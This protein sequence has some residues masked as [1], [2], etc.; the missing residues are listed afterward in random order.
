MVIF[1]V[2]AS[3]LIESMKAESWWA[4][5]RNLGPEGQIK[6]IRSTVSLQS[7][8]VFETILARQ[9]PLRSQIRLSGRV[10]PAPP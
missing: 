7:L 6:K 3:G 9:G 5:I 8:E 4:E 1:E 10:W 2:E